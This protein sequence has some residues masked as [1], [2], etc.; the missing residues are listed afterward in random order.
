MPWVLPA[1]LYLYYE[2]T[3]HQIVTLRAPHRPYSL[4]PQP[5]L[6]G[7][8]AEA[9]VP[10]CLAFL[11]LECGANVWERKSMALG[12]LHELPTYSLRNAGKETHG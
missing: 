12:T 2:Q 9:D 5:A 7:I 10:A 1:R 8:L 3:T 6:P 11:S 4:K